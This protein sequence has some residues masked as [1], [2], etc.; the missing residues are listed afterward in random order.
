MPHIDLPN[1][2]PGILGPMKKYPDTGRLISKLV[3]EVLRGPSPL[4]PGQRELIA[5]YTSS[6]NDCSFC[7]GAHS[8]TAGELLGDKTL[9]KQVKSNPETAPISE[10]MKAL[11][12]ISAKVQE[13]PQD[14]T[15]EDVARARGEGATDKAIHDT[16]LI[17]A[18]FSMCNR[19]VD[20]LDTQ[21]PETEEEYD[22]HGKAL[23]AKGYGLTT[24]PW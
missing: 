19:Y 2:A 18:V 6:R 10:K 7:T 15:S 11:L 8:A 12:A 5:A 17:T 1:D 4:E 16:V 21:L 9:V 24:H 20:G 22:E 14:V 23:A 3:E 13:A